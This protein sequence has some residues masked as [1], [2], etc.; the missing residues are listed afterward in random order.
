MATSRF[1]V[2]K[3]FSPD[4]E[5]PVTGLGRSGAPASRSSTNGTHAATGSVTDYFPSADELRFEC[6]RREQEKRQAEEAKRRHEE[7]RRQRREEAAE[8]VLQFARRA[9]DVGVEPTKFEEEE[10]HSR[11]WVNGYEI[12]TFW[13]QDRKVHSLIVVAQPSHYWTSRTKWRKKWLGRRRQVKR[14]DL[15]PTAHEL[16][17]LTFFE[18]WRTSYDLASPRYSLKGPFRAANVAQFDN[19]SL[20]ELREALVERLVSF[21]HVEEM[22]PASVDSGSP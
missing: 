11:R 12:P 8:L 18:C 17:H 1:R 4:V 6:Q 19:V 15:Q 3:P 13:E 2:R 5:D 16:P 21:S 9:R 22:N 10:V 7:E 14:V 20:D